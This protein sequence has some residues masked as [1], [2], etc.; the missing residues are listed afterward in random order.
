MKRYQI[1][2]I[3]VQNSLVLAQPAVAGAR[4]P[5]IDQETAWFHRFMLD[6]QSSKPI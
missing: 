2:V 4:L 1:A 5:L 3:G 6:A